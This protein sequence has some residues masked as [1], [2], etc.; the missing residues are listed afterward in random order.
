MVA[1]LENVYHSGALNIAEDD[2][3]EHTYTLFPGTVFDND[4]GVA[5]VHIDS[6]LNLD[7][8][9]IR[10]IRTGVSTVAGVS[11]ANTESASGVEVFRLEAA[12]SFEADI[13][14]TRWKIRA[15]TG[16]I[17]E[18]VYQNYSSAPV[19]YTHLTLPT[20]YSV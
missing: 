15:A 7:D 1:T 17:I 4:W 16:D 19:S 8:V 11:Q 3:A 6:T 20:I 2:N 10:F 12:N 13:V 14:G 9:T 5:I 18:L